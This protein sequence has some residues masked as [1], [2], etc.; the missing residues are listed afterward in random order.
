MSIE[1]KADKPVIPSEIPI[2]FVKGAGF[3][4]AHA[5]GVWF[6]TDPHGNL[7]LTFY[8]ERTPIPKKMVLK[9]NEQGQP[10]GEDETQRE[11]K[12]GVVREMEIDVVMSLHAASGFYEMFGQ[13]L[14]NAIH[15][16]E[17]MQKLNPL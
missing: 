15:N 9:L 10:I 16:A 1:Q 3:R 4:V 17:M 12:Q 7:H 13:N 8:S 2:H 6:G 5:S 14:K 11:G